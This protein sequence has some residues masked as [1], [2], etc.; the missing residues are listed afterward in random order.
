MGPTL[1]HLNYLSH[2][3]AKQLLLAQFGSTLTVAARY[4]V[5]DEPPDIQ[6]AGMVVD[7]QKRD[8]V[9]VLS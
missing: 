9:I 2:S 3:E 8:L 5:H 1:Q 6:H 4:P 7:V